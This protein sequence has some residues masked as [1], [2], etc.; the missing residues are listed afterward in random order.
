MAGEPAAGIVAG[1]DHVTTV[2]AERPA[3]LLFSALSRLGLFVVRPYASYGD[4]S[5]GVV[6]L[7][8]MDLEVLGITGAQQGGQAGHPGGRP[9]HRV[10]LAPVTLEG[11]LAELDRRGVRHGDPFPFPPGPATRPEYTAVDLPGLGGDTLGVQF[12]AYPE[13]PHTGTVPPRDLAGVR[14]T[15]R[16]VLGASD[17]AAARQRWAALFSPQ[18]MDPSG[19]WRPRFGPV[20]E[21]RPS[22]EDVVEEIGLRVGSLPV[23][24]AAFTAAGLTVE[25]DM[26]AIGTVPAR[27]AAAGP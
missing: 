3:R 8:T 26:V 16:V 15:E 27:L 20:L 13:G 9:R 5:S 22:G 17:A 6:R 24:R 1:V 4:F 21:V 10:S 11:L 14:K 18:P 25:D 2:L 7:G 12:C 19:S 23:A